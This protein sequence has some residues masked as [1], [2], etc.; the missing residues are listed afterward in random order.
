[1]IIISLFKGKHSAVDNEYNTYNN[2]YIYTNQKK[3]KSD[4]GDDFFDWIDVISV[5]LI[6]VILVF[7]FAFRV[8]TVDGLSME[9]TFHDGEK[10]VVSNIGYIPKQGDVVIVSRNYYN[11]PNLDAAFESNRPI[12]K[13][14]I[15]TENQTVSFVNGRVLVD[16][17]ELNEDYIKGSTYFNEQNSAFD[18]DPENNTYTARVPAGCVFV[19]G[20]NREH[21][22]DSRYPDIGNRGNGMIDK[23]YII[24]KVYYRIF[25]FN[26]LGGFK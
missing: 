13:R 11:D 9:D 26:K 16:G 19:L 21:S 3:S 20:D 2:S 7:T 8:A 24:G 6:S 5:A 14:V 4:K 17:N 18:F 15:A 1:M 23:E 22:K 12:I 10:V 25:P